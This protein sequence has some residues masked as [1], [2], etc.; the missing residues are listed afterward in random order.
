MGHGHFSYGV[1][2]DFLGCAPA[3]FLRL[4]C[5]VPINSCGRLGFFIVASSFVS[6]LLLLNLLSEGYIVA[7]VVFFEGSCFC[8]LLPHHHAR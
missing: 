6:W 1:V 7:R 3:S 5:L 4:G 2:H 8:W